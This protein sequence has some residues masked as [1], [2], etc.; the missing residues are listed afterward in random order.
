MIKI[1]LAVMQGIFLALQV[2]GIINWEWYQYLAPALL[3][4]GALLICFTI[5]GF[6]DFMSQNDAKEMLRKWHLD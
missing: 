6:I 4:F 5:I 2:S 3:W 1:T